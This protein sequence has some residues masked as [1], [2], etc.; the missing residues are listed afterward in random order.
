MEKLQA[1]LLAYKKKLAAAKRAGERLHAF[2]DEL[3]CA[4]LVHD[5]LLD[6]ANKVSDN[7]E[8]KSR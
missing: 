7:W 5:E 8:N 2:I 1:D 6:K 3:I 4:D